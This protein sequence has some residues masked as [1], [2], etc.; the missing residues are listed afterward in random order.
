MWHVPSSDQRVTVLSGVESRGSFFR[1][2][3]V[4][5]LQGMLLMGKAS[6]FSR[7]LS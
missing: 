3:S 6:L 2:C 1:L 7:D 5:L 4:V